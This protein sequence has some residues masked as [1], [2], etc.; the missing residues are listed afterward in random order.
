MPA[1]VWTR[2]RSRAR[3]PARTPGRP[4]TPTT[5][6]PVAVHGVAQRRPAVE[7]WRLRPAQSDHRRRRQHGD[8][9]ILRRASGRQP[10]PDRP[11]N[12][13]G[14]APVIGVADDHV[15]APRPTAASGVDHYDVF[16]DGRRAD[17]TSL[18]VAPATSFTWTDSGAGRD[19]RGRRR[20][21]ST[22]WWRSTRRATSSRPRPDSRSSSTRPAPSAPTSVIALATPTNQRP[23]FSWVAPD[24]RLPVDH[25]KV[26]RN[27]AFAARNVA[28]TRPPS[29]TPAACD[30]SYTY[31]V[32]AAEAERA[33]SASPRRRS[34]SSTTRRRRRPRRR[35][36]ERRARRLDH[37]RLARL[38]RRRGSGVARYV[39]RRSLSS[40]APA[41][42]AD[43]D[44]ICQGTSTSCTDATALNGKLYSYAVFAVDRAGNRPPAGIAPA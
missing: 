42:I 44:A 12:P 23:Q 29:P 35:D 13:T 4:S 22:R 9:P 8:E 30:S 37:G 15:R 24:R 21:T 17:R 20:P 16:R 38:E 31:Q 33:R 3:P 6:A 28:G 5:A 14:L 43:G 39:V 18:R 10:R 27:G 32:V 34:R 19:L 25:Y 1:R 11:G 7:R 2:S 36:R 26:Y 41:T 40:V